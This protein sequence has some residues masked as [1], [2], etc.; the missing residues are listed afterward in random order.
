MHSSTTYAI[1]WV[2]PG[3]HVSTHYE[4]LINQYLADVAAESGHTTNV[5]SVATQ[6]YDANGPLDYASSFAGSYVDTNAFPGSGCD[7]GVDAVCL[8][9]QQLQEELQNVLSA[10]GWHGSPTTMF[11][12]MT[13]DGVGSCFDATSAECTTN[14]YCAYHNYFTDSN[15]ERVIY[16]NE[17]YDATIPGCD[18]G[19][20]PNGDDADS[21]INTISH[22]H[23]EAITDPFEDAWWNFGSGQENGDNC[24]WIF[25]SSLGGTPGV[26]EYNQTLNGHHYYLQ[27]EW[28]NDGSDCLQHYLGIPVN[29]GL[30]T[31]SGSA[32]LGQRLSATAGTWSQSPTSYTYQWL[33]CS[34]TA[35]VS[36]FPFP[37]DT[38]AIYQLTEADVGKVFRVAVTATNAAGSSILAESAPTG[39][40]VDVPHVTSVP[41]VTGAPSVGRTLSTTSGSW[42]TAATF[43]YQWQRCAPDGNGC[44]AIPNATAIAYVVVPADLGHKLKVVVSATN[45]AGIV[46]IAS[47]ATPQIVATPTPTRAP[48]IA[49]KARVHKRLSAN[50]GTW[51]WA[52]TAY[53]YQWL[54]CSRT[55]GRCTEIRKATH[56]TYRVT[57]RDAGHRLRL[58]VTAT[59]AAGARSATSRP[60]GRV[61]VSRRG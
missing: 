26:N 6:Y 55:G 48:R 8:T 10:K 25:G 3:Y 18:S 46:T 33:R 13:P 51:T 12:L 16:A 23:N 44:T 35:E 28:S 36:C 31:L 19:S 21:T 7:D 15:A 37:G 60:T 27:E 56:T 41:D 54:R 39:V 40:V 50:H 38:G 57:K 42:D 4:S 5:Y 52:P 45:A 61:P 47:A 2:P 9:D 29:F 59:N 43:A 20:S 14:V 22:E 17:A 11:F 58:R 53:R 1:Y 34:S 24:A 49:G 32:G 30:P